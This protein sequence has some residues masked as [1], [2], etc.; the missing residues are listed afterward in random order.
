MKRFAL[1]A[2]LST[3]LATPAL[4]DSDPLNPL[5]VGMTRSSVTLDAQCKTTI[6]AGVH[7]FFMFGLNSGVNTGNGATTTTGSTAAYETGSGGAR[8]CLVPD[9]LTTDDVI[10]GTDTIVHTY[11]GVRPANPGAVALTDEFAQEFDNST[12]TDD[13]YDV[14]PYTI[15]WLEYTTVD[16]TNDLPF[17]TVWGLPYR[18]E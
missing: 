18:E 11:M 8:V 3:F 5:R 12:I 1:L 6:R 14:D 13:C 17:L 4:A 2:L 9:A 10:A 16:A 7:C 15:F